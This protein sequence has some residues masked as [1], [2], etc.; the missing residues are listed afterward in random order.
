[1]GCLIEDGHSVKGLL[2]A[3]DIANSGMYTF[4]TTA[5]KAGRP[6][7][8]GPSKSVIESM[9]ENVAIPHYMAKCDTKD[10]RAFDDLLNFAIPTY[11]K[12]ESQQVPGLEDLLQ[13]V[14]ESRASWS[15]EDKRDTV[16]AMEAYSLSIRRQLKDIKRQLA[17]PRFTGN[18]DKLQD[19]QNELEEA[20]VRV[21]E[22]LADLAA[23][24]N[25]THAQAYQNLL[26]EFKE[27]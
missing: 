19:T 6:T 27:A 18:K 1:M 3:Q 15:P 24:D 4:V 11:E 2:T 9:F 7:I 13:H 10:R 22:A 5:S 23:Q 16:K 17:N 20:E 21:L 12:P 25:V 26:Q 8:V 14:S